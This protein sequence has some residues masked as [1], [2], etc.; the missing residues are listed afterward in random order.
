MAAAKIMNFTKVD[1]ETQIL[2]GLSEIDEDLA[3]NP[4]QYVYV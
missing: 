2:T 4:R 3:M 1:L